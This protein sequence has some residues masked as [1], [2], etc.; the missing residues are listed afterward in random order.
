M[1]TG[2]PGSS[3]EIYVPATGAQCRLASTPYRYYAHGM[4]GRTVCGGHTK[5]C[6]TFTDGDWTSSGELLEERFG[7][8]GW[9]SPGGPMMIGGSQRTPSD[10]TTEIVNE[11]PNTFSFPLNYSIT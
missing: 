10:L 2:G 9:S 7:L 5:E 1:I 6:V 8:V 4:A 3:V 11:G